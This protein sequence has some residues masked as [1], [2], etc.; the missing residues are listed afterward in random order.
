MKFRYAALL[1]AVTLMCSPLL[2]TAQSENRGER[3]PDVDQGNN[4]NMSRIAES[5]KK[6]LQQAAQGGLAEV[7]LGQLAVTKSSNEQV[8]KFGQR[9]MRDHSQVNRELVQLATRDGI[10]LPKRPDPKDEALRKRLEKLNGDAFDRAYMQSMVRDHK[11]DIAEFERESHASQNADVKEFATQT[12]PQ[13][14]SHLQQA[15]E[16][17]PEAKMVPSSQKSRQP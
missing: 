5:D 1:I 6:F 8:K 10:E 12:L 17:A 7:Q 3:E 13:L 2:S 4:Q 9:M 16:I 11:H 14:K 15:Q